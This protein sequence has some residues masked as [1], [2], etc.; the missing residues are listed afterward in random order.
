MRLKYTSGIVHPTNPKAGGR[1][2]VFKK[3]IFQLQTRS[4]NMIHNN[5]LYLKEEET[6]DTQPTT[7]I[8][9]PMAHSTDR[10]TIE[11]LA[12]VFQKVSIK[13]R[14]HNLSIIFNSGL[15]SVLCNL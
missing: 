6:K 7:H 5:K 13:E 15:Y 12:L 3:K 2:K 1:T 14:S 11:A 8:D 10:N 9:T 4:R